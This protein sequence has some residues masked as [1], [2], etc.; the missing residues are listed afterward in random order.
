[1]RPTRC[2][3]RST[4]WGDSSRAY[5][6]SA[7]VAGSGCSMKCVILTFAAAWFAFAPSCA[8]AGAACSRL[9]VK[10]SV[11]IAG[12]EL[13]LADL[14]SADTCLPVRTTAA[15]INLGV[16]PLAGTVRVIAGLQVRAWLEDLGPASGL[17]D[18]SLE[19]VP[20][21]IMVQR[22]GAKKPAR[23]LP[24]LHCAV[25]RQ[26]RTGGYRSK[27]STVRRRSPSPRRRRWS[28]P[29]LPGTQPCSVGNFLC[30]AAG[31]R[32]AFRFWCGPLRHL[33]ECTTRDRARCFLL[34]SNPPIHL[35]QRASS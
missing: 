9:R 8:D 17:K 4:I 20:A 13:T 24:A 21:K 18:E 16:T 7:V 30:A 6:R 15:R 23:R 33:G 27:I 1:M 19:D 12:G 31:L 25:H 34:S 28:L 3:R 35:G 11:Q 2:C 22:G 32:I 29:N 26:A 5:S 14:L 10:D